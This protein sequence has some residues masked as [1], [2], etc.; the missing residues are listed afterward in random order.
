[1]K[2]A[3]LLIPLLFLCCC[4]QPLV[5]PAPLPEDDFLVIAHRGA[6]A[7]APAHTLAAYDIA[8]QMG[9]D[10]IEID[11]HRTK[12]GK[13]VALHD[14]VVAFSTVEQAV[15][16]VTLDELKLYFPGE[17]FNETYPDY[18]S[19]AFE[20][21]QVL[22]LEEILLHFEDTANYYIELKSPD[23][24]PGIEEELLKQL[25]EHGLLNRDDKIPKVIIQSYDSASLKKVFKMEPSIPLIQLL[26]F[27]KK[28]FLSTR[29]IRKIKSYASGIGLNGDAVTKDFIDNVHAAG[30]HVHPYT[31]NESEAIYTMNMLGVDGIFTDR[32][33]VAIRVRELMK[34]KEED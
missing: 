10:Y 12:D 13:I 28:A 29:E 5:M 7:Y 25:T 4:S 1:M 23:T 6:S 3:F 17:V 2:K 11:L 22:N 32:P 8:T 20:Q 21:L 14:A 31:V 33:D 24:Y 16:D 15:A 18:A 9:T 19:P 26:T 27:D 34:Q 30:L